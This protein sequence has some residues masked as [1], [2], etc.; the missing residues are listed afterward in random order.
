MTGGIDEPLKT[1]AADLRDSG[2]RVGAIEL[3]RIA[4]ELAALREERD[5][6]R[7]LV[8]ELADGLL[9]QIEATAALALRP[10][11]RAL[12]WMGQKERQKWLDDHTRPAARNA[13]AKAALGQEDAAENQENKEKQ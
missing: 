6:L 12:S 7:E 2:D 3:E 9:L 1:I 4:A 10:T 8:S 5:R 13:L 11:G